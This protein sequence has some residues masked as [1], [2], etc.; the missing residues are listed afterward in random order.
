MGLWT[1]LRVCMK[2]STVVKKSH[3]LSTFFIILLFF[4]IFSGV[5]AYNYS[6]EYQIG[7]QQLETITVEKA[8][9]E[10]KQTIATLLGT[11]E[12]DLTFCQK[13]QTVAKDKPGDCKTEMIIPMIEDRILSD[14]SIPEDVGKI[15]GLFD[16]GHGG[17]PLLN[18]AKEGDVYAT[19]SGGSVYG[20][21]LTP[22]DF[23]AIVNKG[24]IF[25]GS[26]KGRQ[27]ASQANGSL[28][29]AKFFQPLN[30]IITAD[31]SIEKIEAEIVVQQERLQKQIYIQSLKSTV[32]V[33]IC[34]VLASGVGFYFFFRTVNAVD[35]QDKK[36]ADSENRV[37]SLKTI[38]D[39]TER[40]KNTAAAKEG[41]LDQILQAAD[42][43][44]IVV[45]LEE[46][47]ILKIGDVSQGVG[48]LLGYKRGELIGQPAAILCG[49][50]KK[51][52]MQTYLEV[53]LTERSISGDLDLIKKNGKALQT[54]SSVHL[55][56]DP[57]TSAN[58]LIL[59]A[60]DISKLEETRQIL[61]DTEASLVEAHKMEAIG[62]LT[63][64]I[65]HDFNNVLSSIVGYSELLKD[66]LAPHS[67]A[68]KDLEQIQRSTQRASELVK[69]I[70][71]F[72]RKKGRDHTYFEP[73]L[74]VKESLKMLRST[75]PA[76]IAIESD[77]AIDG[78]TIYSNANRFHQ[79]FMNLCTNAYQSMEDRGGVLEVNL[80]TISKVDQAPEEFHLEGEKF[81]EIVVADTGVGIAPQFRSRVFEPLFSTRGIN[82]RVGMGLCNA[83]H[84]VKMAG[85]AIWFKDRK[86]SG[87]EF[88]VAFPVSTEKK[89]TGHSQKKGKVGQNRFGTLLFVDDEPEIV[90]MAKK[91]LSSLGHTVVCC[92]DGDEALQV[93]TDRPEHFDMIITDQA[94]PGMTGVELAAKIKQIDATIPIILCTGYSA[95]IS[96]E[97]WA[98]YGID[99]F[100]MKPFRRADIA[101]PI[102]ELLERAQYRHDKLLQVS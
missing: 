28:L 10:I 26:Y 37:H 43:V 35:Q 88:H 5:M 41:L 19:G 27:S 91:I 90:N 65:A 38:L 30:W 89:A 100:I 34:I 23:R 49:E 2:H 81:I 12:S 45:M 24:E 59:V 14:K 58:G 40:A 85:G 11:I 86:I 53:L 94:M 75:I 39:K 25:I 68:R 48:N 6:V 72:S 82:G 98:R 99:A 18:K 47:N 83:Y 7:A 70:L 87:T 74:I 17:Q 76:D 60:V 78:T 79:L 71:A 57:I 77:I 16:Y 36:M 63:G 62:L 50:G 56:G 52:L 21:R 69:Q 61:D 67:M 84:M 101:H 80:S 64:G 93:F 54:K 22:P 4:I 3:L 92:S 55:H 73:A 29:Y 31:L 51:E 42:N 95:R 8:K 15:S 32:P 46:N 66:Q 20:S 9:T 1:P 102:Q 96:E 33:F 44:A 97:N 13:K